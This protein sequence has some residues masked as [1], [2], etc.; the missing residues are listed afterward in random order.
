MLSSL[1]SLQAIS[2]W[3]VLIILSLV[4]VTFSS[5]ST[6]KNVVVDMVVVVVA[7]VVAADVVV[8]IVVVV[9][10]VK[11]FNKLVFQ[12]SWVT[13]CTQFKLK[14]APVFTS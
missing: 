13:Q 12:K 6:N 11:S 10:L 8:V 14:L 1:F 2:R 3:H 9:E 4:V 7:V 5:V